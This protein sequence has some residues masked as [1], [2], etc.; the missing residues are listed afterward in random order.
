[1]TD[2]RQKLHAIFGVDAKDM[3]RLPGG[4][5]AEVYGVTLADG[6]RMAVKVADASNSTSTLMIEAEMLTYL[7]AHSPLPL[8]DVL[9]S[10][11]SL[12][13]LS[14]L[15][16]DSQMSAAVQRDA[17]DHIAALHQVRGSS[18]GF[19]SDTVIGPLPQP[20][21]QSDT[22]LPFFRDHRLLYMARLASE[23]H[24]LPDDLYA[25]LEQLASRL[26]R[27]LTEPDF[28]ALLH[29]DLWT[30]NMLA[31]D[32][33]ITGFLDPAIYYGHPE[34][35]LAYSTLFGTFGQPFFERYAELNPAW[36]QRGFFAQ[37]RDLYNL[38]PLLVHV[39]LFGGGYVRSVREIVSR[40]R[41]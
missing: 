22:W 37:R 34:M 25:Q 11:P 13:V 30:T 24:Q 4:S 16:G 27:W 41:G 40:Y 14:W 6:Q 23:S 5:I 39:R 33:R 7:A 28:P 36:D 26:D 31:K 20:N 21:P 15:D 12:L 8:P 35:D 19:A 10:E 17:A 2:V 1:M 9:H 29:G 32:G 38:W 18:F 3:R